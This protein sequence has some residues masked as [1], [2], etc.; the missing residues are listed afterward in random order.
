V[1]I[2]SGEITNVNAVEAG[3]AINGSAVATV[4]A[5]GSANALFANV[6]DVDDNAFVVAQAKYYSGTYASVTA[7]TTSA[8][9]TEVSGS[10]GTLTVG[11][12]GSYVYVVTNDNEDIQALDESE[13]ITDTFTIQ[14]SDGAGGRVEQTLAVT[15]YGTNDAPVAGVAITNSDAI[16]AGVAANGS[17]VETV[18]ASGVANALF[19]GVSDV[20]DSVFVVAQAKLA[21]GTY[22][23]VTAATTSANGTEVSGSYGTLTVGADGSYVY[24]VTNDNE[25]IQALDESETITDTFTIQVSDGAGGTADKTLNVIVRGTN[26]VPISSGEITNVNAVEAGVAINGS[27]VATVNATGSANAL[28]AN[29]SDVDDNAF[30]VAQAKYYSG[31]YASVTAATTSANGTEVSGSYGKLT[32]GADGSYVYV[33][34]NDNEDIQA[35]DESETITDTFTIQVSD[36]AGGRVEQTLAV[37]VDGT[38]DAPVAG[39]AITNE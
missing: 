12:D 36:G 30:V 15:V 23:S 39:V 22:A 3:V 17:S 8:N 10:Y 32:V 35:L 5:T 31:T 19:A 21:G 1:P 16:E 27:A 24:V 37:T 34:T 26:D 9:G 25:D 6:S 4:N 20:D 14:V 28:F 11:A 13:T 29:V 33:V 2:S 18:N 7:A 38:N